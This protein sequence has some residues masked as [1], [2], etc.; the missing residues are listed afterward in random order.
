[1]HVHPFSRAWGYAK[2]FFTPKWLHSLHLKFTCRRMKKMY[3]RWQ[4]TWTV[5]E[6]CLAE[7][8]T[9]L[10]PQWRRHSEK[11]SQ[12]RE[13]EVIRMGAEVVG[14]KGTLA[15][16]LLAKSWSWGFTFWL[17][18][19]AWPKAKGT[20]MVLGRLLRCFEFRRPL[21]SL[22]RKCWPKGCIMRPMAVS[23]L[24]C[25]VGG[26]VSASAASESGGGL[27]VSH[28]LTDEGRKKHVVLA[29]PV[30]CFLA[31]YALQV[32]RWDAD[33]GAPGPRAQRFVLSLF[34]G[35]VAVMCTLARLPYARWWV[36]PQ[37]KLMSNV[38]VWSEKDGQESSNL[39]KWRMWRTRSS[40][41]WWSPWVMP[42]C[43]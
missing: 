34:D 40:C 33:S 28:Q 18:A 22:L 24:R 35:I 2:R 43:W 26:L 42:S 38:S 29:K 25:P 13:L 36:L 14:K 11:K 15:A 4:V 41:P 17:L 37:P 31:A 1:M 32:C 10:C 20:M 21:M 23:D 3:S 5:L 30:L 39:E 6:R 9:G 7:A 12:H 19:Q 16:P 8:E 27:C